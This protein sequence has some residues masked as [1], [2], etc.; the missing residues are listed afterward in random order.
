MIKK[1]HRYSGGNPQKA[2]EIIEDAMASNYDGF[3]E[4]K[5][6]THSQSPRSTTEQARNER[7][8]PYANAKPEHIQLQFDDYDQYV[9]YCK[10]YNLEVLP[11]S[12]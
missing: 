4:P 7:P 1:L 2:Q 8:H 11:K 5:Q 3:Y 9:E 12:Y 10:K 6:P